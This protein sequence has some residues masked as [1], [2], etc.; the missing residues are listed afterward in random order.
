MTAR[1]VGRRR[2]VRAEASL[3]SSGAAG[4]ALGE[5]ATGRQGG[6]SMERK[7]VRIVD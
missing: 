2:A 6:R 7:V 4:K 3:G 5:G 1:V